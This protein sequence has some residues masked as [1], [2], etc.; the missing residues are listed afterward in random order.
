MCYRFPSVETA[1]PSVVASMFAFRIYGVA[2]VTNDCNVLGWIGSNDGCTFN[3]LMFERSCFFFIVE[4]VSEAVLELSRA[5]FG[6]SW[7]SLGNHLGPLWRLKIEPKI[8]LG[9]LDGFS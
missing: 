7:G 2:L 4:D 3:A 1:M 5:P 6:C 9:A 8:G